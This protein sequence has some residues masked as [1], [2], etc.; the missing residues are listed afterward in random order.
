MKAFI[1]NNFS[2]L[3][4]IYLQNKYGINRVSIEKRV[5]RI[6]NSGVNESNDLKIIVSLTSY[7]ESLLD[8][9]LTLYSL[10]SQTYKPSKII[11]NLSK[12]EFPEGEKKLPIKVQN[13]LKWG[14]EI[15]WCK[16]IGPYTKLI[17]TLK[18]YP[19]SIIVTA[20]DDIFYSEKWL[21]KLVL[22]YK[23]DT[24][25]IHTHRATKIILAKNNYPIKYTEWTS[26]TQGIASYSNFIKGFGGVL[27]P[28]KS[29]H[30]DVFNEELFQTLSPTA[31]DIWFWAMAVLNNTK[32]KVVENHIEHYRYTNVDRE[33]TFQGLTLHEQNV[34]QGKNDY[35]I[36]NVLEYYSSILGKLIAENKIINSYNG[37]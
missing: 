6:Q 14:V 18:L 3:Y 11:L 25:Y 20:D 1:K 29:L 22:S 26:V 30:N 16:D 35:Q 19:N 34:E 21:E 10:L 28:P 31:D 24:E 2:F 17:P 36:K 4:K 5:S 8:I 37:V 15:N 9:H 23:K 33:F 27:Y 13:I 12:D 7:G 32:I